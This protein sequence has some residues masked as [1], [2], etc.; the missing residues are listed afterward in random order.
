MT[1][2]HGMP[3]P[4]SCVDCMDDGPVAPPTRRTPR[5]IDA[6]FPARYD[7]ECHGCNL[8]ISV[9]QIIHRLSDERYVHQ[10]CES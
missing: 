3:S 7:G 10:G 2:S 8:P 1:C 5:T 4:A 9:G 6:T